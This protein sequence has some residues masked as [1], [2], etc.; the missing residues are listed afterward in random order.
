ML[1]DLLALALT[2]DKRLDSVD[3]GE[4][5]ANERRVETERGV[6]VEAQQKYPRIAHACLAA[7]DAV[8]ADASNA[9]RLPTLPHLILN[10]HHT[11]NA[12][13]LK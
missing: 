2:V 7:A 8:V 12:N 1:D 13:L 5:D 10:N 11:V 9:D 3:V 4:R 6:V